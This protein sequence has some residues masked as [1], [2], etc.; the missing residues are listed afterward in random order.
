MVNCYSDGECHFD[1]MRENYFDQ[2]LHLLKQGNFGQRL[3]MMIPMLYIVAVSGF[4]KIKKWGNFGIFFYGGSLNSRLMILTLDSITK[5]MEVG[6]V[7]FLIKLLCN[8]VYP[9][10]P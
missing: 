2:S 7:I 6:L 5:L 8:S 4:L 1:F 10:F 9:S 3:V